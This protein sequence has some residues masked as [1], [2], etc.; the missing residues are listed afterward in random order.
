[1]AKFMKDNIGTSDPDVL[2]GLGLLEAGHE[3]LG[4]LRR[5]RPRR[6]RLG[7]AL[8]VAGVETFVSGFK[9]AQGTAAGNDMEQRFAAAYDTW[10]GKNRDRP[11]RHRLGVA[12]LVAGVEGG[13]ALEALVLLLLL[14][15]GHRRR[16]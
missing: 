14:V 8:L 7:V 10:E 3:G 6:H 13:L 5:D 1:V 4:G 11:R 15:P 2:R 12:L 9:Q 16:Q